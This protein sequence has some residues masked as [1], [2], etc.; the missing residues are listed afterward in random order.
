MKGYYSDYMRELSISFGNVDL[1][2]FKLDPSYCRVKKIL[3]LIVPETTMIGDE[4][5]IDKTLINKSLTTSRIPFSR[6]YHTTFGTR[7]ID[8]MLILFSL[9]EL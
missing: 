7:F 9:G 4:I 1:T 2:R 8:K 6:L 3:S 5:R